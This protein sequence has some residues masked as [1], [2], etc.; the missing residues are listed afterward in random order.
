[1]VYGAMYVNLA[2]FLTYL[3]KRTAQLRVKYS[4]ASLV[5]MLIVICVLTIIVELLPV[6]S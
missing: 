5:Y 6:K 4:Y 3:F 1:M 2:F